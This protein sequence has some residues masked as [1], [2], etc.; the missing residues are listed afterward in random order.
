MKKSAII[1]II[2][3]LLILLFAYAAL[4]KLFNHEIF[5]GQLTKFPVLN[6]YPV[7]FSWFIPATEL[8]VALFLF[9]PKLNTY[10]LY[11]ALLLLVL[12]TMFLIL[13]V[14]FDKN[15]PC[16]CWGVISKLG[17]KQHILFNLFFIALSATGITLRQRMNHQQKIHLNSLSR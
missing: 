3:S 6:I 17:W 7:F 15:L 4:S 11:T 8:L 10:G 5:Q 1:N 9:I 12:F 2:C 16:S 14:S 13:M